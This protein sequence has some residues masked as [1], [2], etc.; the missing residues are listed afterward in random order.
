MN[1]ISH[2]NL[3]TLSSVKDVSHRDTVN[4]RF[5]TD[6]DVAI[7]TQNQVTG[8]VLMIDTFQK[9]LWRLQVNGRGNRLLRE[10]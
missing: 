7:D 10:L 6:L 3:R 5:E 1:H 9:L 2:L 8:Y 4:E